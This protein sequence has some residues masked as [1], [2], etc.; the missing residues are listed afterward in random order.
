[1]PNPRNRRWWAM[2]MMCVCVCTAAAAGQE[3]APLL[4]PPSAQRQ[5]GVA[6]QLQQVYKADYDNKTPAG[7]K[8]LAVKLLEQ[9]RSSQNDADTRFVLL[10]EAA[11]AAVAAG[12]L[13]L[14]FEALDEIDAAYDFDTM[15]KRRK[16]LETLGRS[17]TANMAAVY[18]DAALS[19]AESALDGENLTAAS[20][21]LGRAE[22]AARRISDASEAG[23]VRSRVSDVKAKLTEFRR[24][25]QMRALLERNPDNPAAN[26]VVGRYHCLF[27]QDWARGLPMLE[28]GNDVVLQLIA[29]REL[30]ETKDAATMLMLG[31]DWLE[32]AKMSAGAVKDAA[33]RR[34]LHWFEKALPSMTGLQEAAAKE[35]IQQAYKTAGL[36]AGYGLLT[37]EERARL[38]R[39]GNKWFMFAYG[40]RSVEVAMAHAQRLG[41][42]LVSIE[43]AAE[44]RF[45]LAESKR[46]VPGM[47]AFLA[48]G[49]DRDKEGQWKWMDGAPMRYTNWNRGEPNNGG[50][51]QH[52]MRVLRNGKWDD[53]AITEDRIYF[54]Q[55][56]VD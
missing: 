43:S 7:R 45:L 51:N 30:S 50:G 11:N 26:T 44:N 38:I 41:G 5:L 27:R 39:Y 48:G 55:W 1:M 42:T 4:T 34:A 19:V 31:N 2:A 32:Q 56:R 8:A 18:A 28:K 13:E 12:D 9:G 36:P 22:S 54:I 49:T 15:D 24:V 20:S 10:D 25:D 46:E 21:M 35:G 53:V 29:K 16:A 37:E 47:R 40:S 6:L 3:D 14:A 23:A 17:V 33:A 52:Y